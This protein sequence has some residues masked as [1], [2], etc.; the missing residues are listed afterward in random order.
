MTYFIFLGSKITEDGDCSHESKTLAPWKKSCD[1]SRQCIKKQR[2]HFGDKGPSSQ[3]YDFSSSCVQTCEL[4]HKECWAPKN[5]CFRIVVLEKTLESPLDS[6]IKPGTKGN[7]PEYSLDGLLLKL[8][9]QYFDHLMQKA[10]S[11]EKTLML[12][13]IEG[14]RRRGWQRMR[15]LDGITNSMDMILSKLWEIGKD[16]EAWC[17]A[18]HGMA[19][20]DTT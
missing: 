16:R 6:K 10:N 7:H 4:D 17:A 3:S 2:H 12:G 5:G 15:W 1:K 8:K 11:L 20:S 14:R 9:L 13:M 18:V 19:E